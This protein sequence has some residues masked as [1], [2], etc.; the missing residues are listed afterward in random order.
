M[1]V[2]IRLAQ[3]KQLY[4]TDLWKAQQRLLVE[5][6][7]GGLP[8]PLILLQTHLMSLLH[9]FTVCIGSLSLSVSLMRTETVRDSLK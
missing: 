1:T 5:E 6:R 4:L 3:T 2:V 9:K 8:P 7:V